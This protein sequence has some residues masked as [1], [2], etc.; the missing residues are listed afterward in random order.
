MRVAGNSRRGDE[1]SAPLAGEALS[2]RQEARVLKSWEGGTNADSGK[3]RLIITRMTKHEP[4]G[5]QSLIAET[6]RLDWNKI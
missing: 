4:T 5:A 1:T 3:F 2:L 6:I